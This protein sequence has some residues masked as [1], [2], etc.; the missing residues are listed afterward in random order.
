MIRDTC[1]QWLRF[2]NTRRDPQYTCA[3]SEIEQ[4]EKRIYESKT[5][6]EFDEE[7]VVNI[8]ARNNW[9]DLLQNCFENNKPLSC[10][11]CRI[12]ADFGNLDSLKLL[13]LNN[14]PWNE[15]TVSCAAYSGFLEIVIWARAQGC[16]WNS[17]TW[18]Y[19]KGKHPH[20]VKWLEENN[21]PRQ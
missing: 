9:L 14:C 17:Y 10:E 21:C 18:K 13:R 12:A 20:I 4:R 3:L 19:T 7:E 1:V 2:N 8:A 15:K 6:S 16:P 5:W 11:A